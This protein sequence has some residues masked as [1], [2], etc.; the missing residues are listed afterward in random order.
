MITYKSGMVPTDERKY[1]KPKTY[2]K[3]FEVKQT[4]VPTGNV[5][6]INPV[7]IKNY[8]AEN[9]FRQQAASMAPNFIHEIIEL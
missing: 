5:R 8:R 4:H 7:L 3:R 9:E 6:V 2:P 1:I